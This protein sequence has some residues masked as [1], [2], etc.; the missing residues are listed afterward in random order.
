MAWPL[1]CLATVLSV[2]H[3]RTP[4]RVCT[5]T[6]TQSLSHTYVHIHT[7][8]VNLNSISSQLLITLI[9]PLSNAHCIFV[10]KWDFSCVCV[11]VRARGGRER[12]GMKVQ[13]WGSGKWLFVSQ[14]KKEESEGGGG[15]GGGGGSALAAEVD[16]RKQFGLQRAC[17]AKSG[18]WGRMET[19]PLRL[20]ASRRRSCRYWIS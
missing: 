11:C 15:G 17:P 5:Q 19:F 18:R 7:C 9:Q 12:S 20:S 13:V 16:R 10:T 6:H 14:Y 4:M 8:K 1:Y 2:G 3:A